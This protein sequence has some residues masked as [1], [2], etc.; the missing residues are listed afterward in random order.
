MG[1]EYGVTE[2]CCEPDSNIGVSIVGSV[3]GPLAPPTDLNRRLMT[4][5][6]VVV[7]F[8]YFSAL[9][10]QSTYSP[11]KPILIYKSFIDLL[12]KH[13]AQ[14]LD[15]NMTATL[16][17]TGSVISAKGAWLSGLVIPY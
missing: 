5:P 7:I 16:R 15:I 12:L 6:K 8:F 9:P 3:Y 4:N 1:S 2:N 10:V 14:L 13:K 11:F 17:A